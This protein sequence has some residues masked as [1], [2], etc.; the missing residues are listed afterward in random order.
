MDFE[1][2][3]MPM[4]LPYELS[5]LSEI[6]SARSESLELKKT[7][8]QI[9]SVLDTHMNLQM[10][11]IT[12]LDQDSET[13]KI[14]VAHGISEEAKRMGE[15]RVGEGITAVSYTHLTLPTKRIV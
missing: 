10:G 6:A 3:D 2:N 9:L 13:I 8:E 1:R 12:L 15:Y 5:L 11:T 14:V 4:S 7:L